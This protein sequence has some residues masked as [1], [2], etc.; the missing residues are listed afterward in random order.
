MAAPRRQTQGSA[1]PPDGKW[2][3]GLAAEQFKC[4]EPNCSAGWQ[5][6]KYRADRATAPGSWFPPGT[7][8]TARQ[9]LNGQ[10]EQFC[11]S[12][13]EAGKRRAPGDFRAFPGQQPAPPGAA[14][15]VT[16]AAAAPGGAGVATSRTGA[17]H[18]TGVPGVSH[19][20][21]AP[22]R[23]AAGIGE[24]DGAQGGG[25]ANPR[26]AT[27]RAVKARGTTSRRVSQATLDH[28]LTRLQAMFPNE[29]PI[30]K[31]MDGEPDRSPR[32]QKRTQRHETMRNEDAAGMVDDVLERFRNRVPVP[33]VAGG[34]TP[35]PTAAEI[36]GGIPVR[37]PDEATAVA[38]RRAQQA[39]GDYGGRIP[40]GS[41]PVRARKH[42]QAGMPWTSR[43]KRK[44]LQEFHVNGTYVVIAPE[45]S[46]AER[47]RYVT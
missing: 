28:N 45:V 32:P 18:G 23:N 31:T 38:L 26:A 9:G 4:V 24:S 3:S 14:I 20:P 37:G 12:H 17:I 10:F 42:K 15:T 34:L 22:V 25:T 40:L 35:V 1:V 7:L 19:T 27:L 36:A 13:V 16:G 33:T 44:A 43:Q 39:F 2:Y 29:P 5:F 46:K 21:P 30:P 8:R 41:A 11:P 47:A 6:G